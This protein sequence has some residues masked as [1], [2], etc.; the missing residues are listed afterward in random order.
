MADQPKIVLRKSDPS[1]KSTDDQ[2][3][4]LAQR[5]R[6]VGEGLVLI[7]PHAPYCGTSSPERTALVREIAREVKHHGAQFVPTKSAKDWTGM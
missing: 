6:C 4:S 7:F 5:S 3:V 2:I 1:A